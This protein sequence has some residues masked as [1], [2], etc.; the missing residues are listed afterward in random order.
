MFIP[1]LLNK[2]SLSA[3]AA[4]L[5]CTGYKLSKVSLLKD[6]YQKGRDQFVPITVTVLAILF[7]DLLVGI[8]VGIIVRLFF[9]IRSNFR[10]SVFVVH[11]NANYLIRFRKDVSFL[12]KPAV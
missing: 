9:M 11:D 6:I 7:S 3:L 2:I 8:V 12:N 4:V 5:M 1:R 10:S